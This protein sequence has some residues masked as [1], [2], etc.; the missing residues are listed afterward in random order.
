[1]EHLRSIRGNRSRPSAV[2]FGPSRSARPESICG[3][4]GEHSPARLG[5][6]NVLEEARFDQC[7]RERE[8]APAAGRLDASHVTV[9]DHETP[10]TFDL[11][12]VLGLEA[13]K[14][15]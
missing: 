5:G 8:R 1:M 2:P 15:G 7:W 6:F 12:N 3:N 9:L 11:P 14:L 13:G 4:L 10:D